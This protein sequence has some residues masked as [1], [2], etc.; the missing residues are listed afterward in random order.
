MSSCVSFGATSLASLGATA[1]QA[2]GI[3]TSSACQAYCSSSDFMSAHPS[4]S[5]SAAL[6]IGGVVQCKCI[7]NLDPSAVA[8]L[9]TSHD[10]QPCTSQGKTDSGLC[11]QENALNGA[12]SALYL[13]PVINPDWMCIDISSLG[14]IAGPGSIQLPLNLGGS[15]VKVPGI[16]SETDCNMY[17]SSDDFMNQHPNV[18]LSTEVQVGGQL[19][20]ICVLGLF[21]DTVASLPKSYGCAPCQKFPATNPAADLGMCG[22]AN[23]L[24]GYVN[25]VYLKTLYGGPISSS[26]TLSSTSSTATTTSTTSTT[27]SGTKLTITATSPASSSYSSSTSGSSTHSSASSTLASGSSASSTTKGGSGSS[28]IYVS[29]GSTLTFM[30][31]TL[32]LVLA[33]M[34]F[35]VAI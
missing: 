28:G 9:P 16:S 1:I 15:L 34:L 17:C 2:Q 33:C 19:Q 6:Q 3:T 13:T 18:T 32:G 10:C 26:W 29:S 23:A 5:Y 4:V 30:T 12:I 35:M 11:G 25:P 14:G 21:Q 24:D 20:C 8:N 22:M 31:S 27:T 7:L